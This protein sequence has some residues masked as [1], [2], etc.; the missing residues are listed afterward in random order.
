[1]MADKQK[2]K[3]RKRLFEAHPYCHWCGA[4]VDNSPFV[5]HQPPSP[6]AAT[7]DHRYGKLDPRRRSTLDPDAMSVLSCWECNNRRGQEDADKLGIKE[8]RR[9]SGRWPKKDR[10][11][12]GLRYFL[13]T[14][15]H[16][17]A[18]DKSDE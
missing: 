3:R 4:E 17:A 14:L 7:I 9:R 2:Q 15:L 18:L 16:R 10:P 8:L 1:M 13:R 11:L 12:V 6:D 5:S